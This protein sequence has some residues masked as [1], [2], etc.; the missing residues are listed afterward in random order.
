MKTESTSAKSWAINDAPSKMDIVQS[1]EEPSQIQNY[2]KQRRSAMYTKGR[3]SR[4]T[5]GG[6]DDAN[7]YLFWEGKART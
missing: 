5:N 4:S 7:L 6:V 3:R 2:V 1:V